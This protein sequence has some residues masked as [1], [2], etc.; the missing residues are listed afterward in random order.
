MPPHSS[1]EGRHSFDVAELSLLEKASHELETIKCNELVPFPSSCFELM[2]S[3]PGNDRC[4]DCGS[5]SPDWAS[6]T[7]GAL[8]CL[9]C[10]GRHRS[11]GV[12]VRNI[13][14]EAMNVTHY[15]R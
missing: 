10:S 8:I 7:Y 5:H 2:R 4:V 11:L 13:V 9:R 12:Q 15:P 6:V 14:V 3:L 1:V